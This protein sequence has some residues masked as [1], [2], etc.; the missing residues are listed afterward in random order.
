MPCYIVVVSAAISHV[1]TAAGQGEWTDS[2][3]G[4]ICS[5]VYHDM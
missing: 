5:T 2:K 3:F 1:S 4:I